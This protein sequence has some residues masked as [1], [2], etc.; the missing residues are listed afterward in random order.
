MGIP[1]TRLEDTKLIWGPIQNI[2]SFFLSRQG[3]DGGRG[4]G[5]WGVG[6][7]VG[8]G[9]V[10]GGGGGVVVVVGGGLIDWGRVTHNICVN[11]I[12]QIY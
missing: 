9:G 6:G 3:P 7:G 8:V 2:T 5:W 10:G 11:T 4:G 12:Y 1:T